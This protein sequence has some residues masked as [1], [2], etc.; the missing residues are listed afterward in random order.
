MPRANCSGDAALGDLRDF[1]VMLEIGAGVDLRT[2]VQSAGNV[3]A[4]RM[5]ECA[6][7]HH[8]VGAFGAHRNASN[9]NRALVPAV[10]ASCPPSRVSAQIPGSRPRFY[11]CKPSAN[12]HRSHWPGSCSSVP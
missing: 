8:L 2:G 6:M 3:V 5:E 7:S 1:S 9:W 10:R 11:T 4:R 12:K